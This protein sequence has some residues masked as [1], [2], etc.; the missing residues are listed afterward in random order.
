M[1]RSLRTYRAVTVFF[2][3]EARVMGLVPASSSGFRGS[4][5]ARV[6][7]GFCEHPGAEDGSQAG[8]GQNDLGV[9]VLPKIGLDLP[10]QAGDLLV[11]GGQD[12]NQGPAEAAYAAVTMSGWPR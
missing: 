4:V 8:L 6:V 11:Q 2:L 12:G 7:A 3:P 1:S 5:P 10:L 9:R